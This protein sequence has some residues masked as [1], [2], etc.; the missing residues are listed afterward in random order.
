MA[1][2]VMMTTSLKLPPA[3]AAAR[4]LPSLTRTTNTRFRV[5][6]SGGKKIKTDKPYGVNGS[7]DLKNQVDASGRKYKVQIFNIFIPTKII[8]LLECIINQETQNAPKY[9]YSEFIG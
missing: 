8:I 3:A 5:E 9:S 2:T 6:A 1:T 4:G 7:L